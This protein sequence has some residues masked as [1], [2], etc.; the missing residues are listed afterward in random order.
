METKKEQVLSNEKIM[1]IWAKTGEVLEFGQAIQQTLL[2]AQLAAK[3]V[4]W[5]IPE[6]KDS[7]GHWT[8]YEPEAD[9]FKSRGVAV[10]PLYS[11]SVV[12]QDSMLNA[13]NMIEGD[14]FWFKGVKGVGKRSLHELMCY[15]LENGQATLGARFDVKRLVHAP[16]PE[17]R[18]EITKIDHE[19]GDFEYEIVDEKITPTERLNRHKHALRICESSSID[20]EPTLVDAYQAIDQ[21]LFDAG[22]M[23][24]PDKKREAARALLSAYQQGETQSIE[25]AARESLSSAPAVSKQEK[26]KTK[27]GQLEIM[28]AA[29]KYGDKR[30]M[31]ARGTATEEDVK[32]AYLNLE[33]CIKQQLKALT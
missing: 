7:G 3:P 9:I 24:A 17:F 15:A 10:V 19:T 29:T 2:A 11:Y 1:K 23:L 22:K 27:A 16:D 8:V 21:A 26:K 25:Q 31:A 18:V 6:N 5:Y 14:L 28:A 33:K 32:H 12:D 13:R 4:A 30:I 20:T